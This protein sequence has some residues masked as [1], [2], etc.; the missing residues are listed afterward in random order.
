MAKLIIPLP[1]GSCFRFRKPPRAGCRGWIIDDIIWALDH[2]RNR[3]DLVAR[4]KI[5][6]TRGE[7][8]LLFGWI[9]FK[10]RPP[11]GKMEWSLDHMTLRQQAF[12]KHYLGAALGNGAKAAR[13]AGYSARRAKQTA[14]DLVHFRKKY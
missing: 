9:L 2:I 6:F 11:Y 12:C 8:A 14:Y 7:V 4:R 13:L 5:E 10:K 3:Y 1:T